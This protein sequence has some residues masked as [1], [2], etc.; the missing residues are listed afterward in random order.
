MVFRFDVAATAVELIKLSPI[1]VSNLGSEQLNFLNILTAFFRGFER[2]PQVMMKLG[3]NFLSLTIPMM[4]NISRGFRVLPSQHESGGCIIKTG[5]WSC[6][7]ISIG[8]FKTLAFLHANL[9]L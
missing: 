3:T 2:F 9:V 4:R 1:L 8:A 6:R 5:R 7:L